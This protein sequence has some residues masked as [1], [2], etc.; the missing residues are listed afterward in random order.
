MSGPAFRAAGLPVYL[1]E[2]HALP[3]VDAAV[4]ISRGSVIDPPGLEGLTRLTVRLMRRGPKGISA[5]AFDEKLDS[6]GASL[7]SQAL[8][9]SSRFYGSVLARNLPKLLEALGAMVTKPAL[10]PK[11]FA[12]LRRKALADVR[13][14]RDDDGALASRALRRNL[15]RDHPYA[16]PIWGTAES[17]SRIRL[18][19]VRAHHAR[20][21]RGRH[22]LLGFAGA[23]HP[24]ELQ[25]LVERAFADLDPTAVPRPRARTPRSRAGRRVVI[26]DKPQRTQNPLYMGS[27]GMRVG[28]PHHTAA[29]VANTGFGVMFTSRLVHE[30]RSRRGWSYGVNSHLGADRQRESWTVWSHPASDNLVDCLALQL[31]LVERWHSTGL[32]TEEVGRA[33]RYLV[34]GHAFERETAHKRL[35]TQLDAALHGL[36]LDYHRDTKRRVGRVSTKAAREA[37]RSFLDP[38]KLTIAVVASHDRSL[39]RALSDLPGVRSVDVVPFV[40]L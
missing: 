24:E 4:L 17:L 13:G 25:P 21:V 29:S 5:D 36:P 37:T 15:F 28:D 30:V 34:K 6:L 14:L 32:S 22:L 31:E 18:A 7:G 16:R 35:W 23:I 19:D 8:P 33:K 40:S 27:L 38:S 39:E 20:L 26:V 1:E 12:R 10:R 3:L 11:D 2:D 9:E